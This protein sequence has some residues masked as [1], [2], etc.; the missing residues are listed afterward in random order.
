MV[1]LFETGVI[2]EVIR[3]LMAGKEASVYV[4]VSDDELRVAKVYK[5]ANERSFRQRAQYSEGRTV[6]NS[7]Q[8]RAMAKGSKYGKSLLEAA[9]QN[10]E[11][12]WL[13]RLHAA[14]V[15]VPVPYHFSDDVLIMEMVADANGEPA[16]RIYDIRPTE[17]EALALHAF[18]IQQVVMMLCEGMVH[19]DLSEYNILMSG[20]GPVIIDLPQAC[21][22]AQ[23]R[24][25][26]KLLKRDLKNLALYL[27]RFAPALKETRFGDE[28]WA[29]FEKGKLFPDTE[30]TG[31]FARS[32]AASD[33]N[34][35]LD[36]IAAA[37]AEAHNAKPMSAYAAKKEKRRAEAMAQLEADRA[38][39]D[40]REERR[41]EQAERV[42][43]A[44]PPARPPDDEP[45]PERARR[46][47]SRNRNR[48]DGPATDG[49][50]SPRQARAPGRSDRGRSDGHQGGRP[51]PD[52][53]PQDRPPQQAAAG[54]DA[55]LRKRRR[56]R[57]RRTGGDG[58]TGGGT[59]G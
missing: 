11:V 53:P 8:R 31:K 30:L 39:Q 24:N 51:P 14:G 36:E 43:R 41:R 55:A 9:W 6:R 23:N 47:R 15:R 49:G 26:A 56:R 28:M 32:T 21:D 57:K 37:A 17:Q 35:V 58:G 12:E 40:A 25:A 42:G 46:R 50:D 2:T 7:R 22:A 10:A 5:S 29:L 18:V 33:T 45:R 3:P 48:G 4:V 34:A 27:G 13:F 52:R 16:P 59:P 54:G 20:D 38:R 1:P 44:P 19:G